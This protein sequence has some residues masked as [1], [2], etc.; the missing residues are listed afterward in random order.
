M[1]AMDETL[2]RANA[3]AN[4]IFERMRVI[5]EARVNQGLAAAGNGTRES[6]SAMA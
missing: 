2:L 3:E 4:E 1:P 5:V 6:N